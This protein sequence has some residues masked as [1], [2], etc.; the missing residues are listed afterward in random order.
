MA[1]AARAPQLTATMA[2]E[3]RVVVPSVPSSAPSSMSVVPGVFAPAVSAL[4]CVAAGTF[5]PWLTVSLVLTAPPL[6]YRCSRVCFVIH[7]S[8][9]HGRS[10]RSGPPTAPPVSAARDSAP[11][12]CEELSEAETEVRGCVDLH[13]VLQQVDWQD[14]RERHCRNRTTEQREAD[15]HPRPCRCTRR[16]LPTASHSTTD[17]TAADVYGLRLPV[18]GTRGLH[19]VKPTRSHGHSPF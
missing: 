5:E 15:A 6:T 10:R 12:R 3:L 8:R 13:A 2:A 19:A 17:S 4:A 14:Q 11:P 1:H 7:C 9:M 16:I 18:D